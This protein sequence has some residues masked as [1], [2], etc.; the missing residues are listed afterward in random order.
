MKL[1][2]I[3]LLCAISYAQ[4]E[5]SISE[6]YIMDVRTCNIEHLLL[7]QCTGRSMG[8]SVADCEV[9]CYNFNR[10]NFFYT[11]SN[12]GCW[13]Y[14]NC[15]TIEY[16]QHEGSTF[17][18]I[19]HTQD[20]TPA[21]PTNLPSVV[22]T[23]K[24]SP[25]PSSSPIGPPSNLPSFSPSSS[26]HIHLL[27]HPSG[28]TKSPLILET[29]S[30]TESPV[31]N[32]A[33]GDIH[34]EPLDISC[35]CTCVSGR[36]GIQCEIASPL[37]INELFVEEVQDDQFGQTWN[38]QSIEIL[39]DRRKR[40]KSALLFFATFDRLGYSS[41]L[42][43]IPLLLHSRDLNFIVVNKT[44]PDIGGIA[45][46]FQEICIQFIRFP[47]LKGD[48]ALRRVVGQSNCHVQGQVL[49]SSLKSVPGTYSFALH[50]SGNLELS[51]FS[52]QR[53]ETSLG[54][55]NHEQ[56]I[57]MPQPFK[58][59]KSIDKIFYIGVYPGLGFS[60][61]LVVIFLKYYG[62]ELNEFDEFVADAITW[63]SGVCA[64]MDFLSDA[65]FCLSLKL[66]GFSGYFYFLAGVL[67]ATLL[68]SIFMFFSRLNQ[69]M[70]K[71]YTI[72]WKNKFPC[73]FTVLPIL[74]I[75]SGFSPLYYD[76][77]MSSPI[78]F[79]LHPDRQAN[80]PFE[81][82]LH[83]L[84]ENVL[85]IFATSLYL[86]REDSTTMAMLSLLFSSIMTFILLSDSVLHFM[87][88]TKYE[89][90]SSKS[91][92][93]FLYTGVKNKF[94]RRKITRYLRMVLG[95]HFDVT[96][97]WLCYSLQTEAYVTL[98]Q[99]GKKRLSTTEICNRV[100]QEI[101]WFIEASTGQ[102][103]Q[104]GE[105]RSIPLDEERKSLSSFSASSATCLFN[106][107]FTFYE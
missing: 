84:V 53:E 98:R 17:Q 14:Q 91:E 34:R 8:C 89:E 3:A 22:P 97:W 99:G 2:L 70:G 64:T 4:T 87:H 66:N 102:I 55:I 10:C 37:W 48:V 13:L 27:T 69:V 30:P 68:K 100:G 9:H 51:L 76:L 65:G 20:P 18:I 6:T 41:S 103:F 40:L 29:E 39:A 72:F 33:C 94:P 36:Y 19:R 58:W 32:V 85:S 57:I 35:E 93:E 90:G 59:D 38:L 73:G 21:F 46:F 82:L 54:N 74:F 79:P 105:R 71:H 80:I 52:F 7:R 101:G 16:R 96:V 42:T 44:V 56:N 86:I 78:D 45:L 23:Q 24:P 92:M 15:S 1:L 75:F 47:Y 77:L 81:K 12:G 95:T 43:R 67:V 60:L 107:Q 62:N 106:N 61:V 83:L 31:C 49:P 28:P 11:N 63:I 25:C 88:S 50:G 104:K 5:Y 26:T